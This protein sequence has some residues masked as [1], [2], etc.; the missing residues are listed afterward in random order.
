M[1]SKH[2][3]I[4]LF[5]FYLALAS[6]SLLAQTEIFAPMKNAMKAGN[7]KDMT[8]L[9]NQSVEIDLDGSITTN[10]KAQA[11]FV[12]RD[13]F[14]KNPPTDF[15]IVHTGSS[16]GGLQFAICSY[17]STSGKYNVLMRVKEVDKKYLVQQV[18]SV[19]E[20][21]GILFQIAEKYCHMIPR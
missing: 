4:F 17:I 14:K 10:S 21:R 15:L 2:Y 13:F 12:F 19:R 6:Q 16:K 18:L 1:M 7:A 5:V 3:F 9:L 20:N 11:E 8:G